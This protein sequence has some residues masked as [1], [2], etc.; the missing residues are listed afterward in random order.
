[1]ALDTFD[2]EDDE[3]GLSLR[4]GG[5][6]ARLIHAR[7]FGFIVEQP[8]GQEYFFHISDVESVEGIYA[9]REGDQVSFLPVSGVKDGKVRW[10]AEQV[11]VIG[12]GN[13]AGRK[14]MESRPFRPRE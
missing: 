5:A 14:G 7:G 13:Q 4:R 6:V 10:R 3:P 1:M 12:T 2:S 11:R 9:L 8:T